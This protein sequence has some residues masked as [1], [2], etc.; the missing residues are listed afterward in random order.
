MGDAAAPAAHAMSRRPPPGVLAG[1]MTLAFGLLYDLIEHGFVV[2]ASHQAG[3]P[4]GGQHMAH[5]IVLA[6]MVLVLAAIVR[7]GVHNNGRTRPEGSPSHA[8]R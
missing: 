7:D 8:I 6:G 4:S 3:G 2:G 1:A 5:L